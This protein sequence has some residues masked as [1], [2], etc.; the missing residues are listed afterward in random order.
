MTAI[1]KTGYHWTFDP[2]RSDG[3]VF[4]D[5]GNVDMPEYRPGKS[6]SIECVFAE[7]VDDPVENGEDT[8][9]TLGAETGFTLGAATGM[10]L[11]FNL[12]PQGHL[13]RYQAVREY[14]RWAGRYASMTMIDGTVR[15]TEHTPSTATVDSIIVALEPGG[16]LLSTDGMWVI[17]DDV[18]D[19][20]ENAADLARLELQFTF[21]ARRDEYATRT[22]LKNALGSDIN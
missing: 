18:D 1:P 3:G 2:D 4:V 22:D 10:S 8:G 13:D 17:L 6:G 21:L 14:T 20:T 5:F 12:D 15:V 9:G 11:G 7:N 19:R 16:D